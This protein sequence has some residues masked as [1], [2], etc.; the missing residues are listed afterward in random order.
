MTKNTTTTETANTNTATDGNAKT[1]DFVAK[2][3]LGYGRRTVWERVGVAWQ[4]EDGSVYLRL[5]GTQILSGGITLYRRDE[6]E[7][8]GA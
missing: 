6:T 5:H 1:P 3:R 8:A 4:N 7:A 2:Q